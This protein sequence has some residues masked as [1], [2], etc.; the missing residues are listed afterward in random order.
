MSPPA[1]LSVV[2]PILDGAAEGIASLFQIETARGRRSKPRF[3]IGAH[4]STFRLFP[5][6]VPL[7]I[8]PG[9]AVGAVGQHQ[10]I[11]LPAC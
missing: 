8:P 6:S 10:P 5:H 1:I 3:H 2:L 4:G 11:M 9:R 7:V